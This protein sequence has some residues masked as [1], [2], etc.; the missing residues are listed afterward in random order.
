MCGAF[1][2]LSK[3][4]NAV[5]YRWRARRRAA[6]NYFFEPLAVLKRYLS[7]FNEIIFDSKVDR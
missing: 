7:I 1:E 6:I 4:Q 5:V 3:L 2:F